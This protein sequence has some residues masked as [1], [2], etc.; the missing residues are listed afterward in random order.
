MKKIGF[1]ISTKENEKRRALLP[2]QLEKIKHKDHLYFE[3]GYGEALGFSDQMYQAYGAHIASRKEILQLDVLCDPK[4]G[5]ASY[6]KD[7]KT[8]QTIF[9]YIHAVQ[10]KPLTDQLISKKATVIA[11][12]DMYNKGR[13][14][15][16]RNNELAGEA[17]IMHAFTLY[18]KLPYDC[19]VAV[20]GRGNTSRGVYRILS[21]LGA[22]IM[23]Y[24]KRTER[25]LRSEFQNFD[26]IVNCVLWDTR[27]TDHL[28]YEKDLIKMKQNAMIIDVSCDR[29]GAIESTI[30]TTI[31]NPTYKKDGVLHYAVDHTPSMIAETSTK[32]FGRIL[33]RFI[34]MIVEDT[35]RLNETLKNAI[36]IDDGVIIDERINIF[37]DRK[38][39]S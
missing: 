32:V 9:G 5:D 29:S 19:K 30:P 15:F 31:E 22:D 37:Q 24:G 36:I 20:I 38:S 2:H 39:K 25:L 6:I 27:R 26:V 10:N 23:V 4:I 13:H 17:A 1:L 11:W 35:Y 3:K 7:I 28:L 33:T 16:W 8:G 21:G 18:G 12:E 34:D 14:T